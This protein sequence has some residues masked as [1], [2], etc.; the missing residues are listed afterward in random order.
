MTIIF[1][2]YNYIFS[3]NI[4]VP[5]SVVIVISFGVESENCT[6]SVLEEYSEYLSLNTISVFANAYNSVSRGFLNR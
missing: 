2:L 6:L 5:L 4:L 3:I 1:P